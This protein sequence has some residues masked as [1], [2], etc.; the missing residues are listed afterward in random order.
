MA[1]DKEQLLQQYQE[2]R[3]QMLAV[4]EGL[5]NEQLIE[6]K[7]DCWS[8]KDHL[9]HLALWDDVRATEVARI[10]AGHTS[11]WRT[12]E[13]QDAAFN[14]LSYALRADLPIDQVKW[15]FSISRQRLLDAIEAATP[16]AMDNSLYGTS[17]IV[18]SHEQEHTEWIKRWRAEK[19]F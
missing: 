17:S 16:R 2:S 10:S 4:L 13:E 7:L 5:T 18:S 19:G 3:R 14:E 15:E 11:A 6:R 8:V 1:E 9:A 12:S